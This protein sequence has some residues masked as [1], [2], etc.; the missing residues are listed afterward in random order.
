VDIALTLLLSS[1]RPLQRSLENNAR[2]DYRVERHGASISYKTDFHT[3]QTYS[4]REL[5][6]LLLNLFSY[7]CLVIE[8][9]G[10]HND[11]CCTSVQHPVLTLDTHSKK[12]QGTVSLSIVVSFISARLSSRHTHATVLLGLD[13]LLR[14]YDPSLVLSYQP[15][16][17]SHD[18]RQQF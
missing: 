5:Y 3:P 4:Q 18:K 16:D 6:L 2:I 8:R 14:R 7:L 1:T 10:H 12:R 9:P 15:L 17:K 13:H 11:C